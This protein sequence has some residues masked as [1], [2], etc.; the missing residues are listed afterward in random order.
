ML[1]VD[2][3][4]IKAL[5]HTAPGACKEDAE[6][7]YGKLQN[8][9]IFSGFCEADWEAIWQRILSTSKDCLI[10]S[11]TSLFQDVNYL[12]GPAQCVKRLVGLSTKYNTISSALRN[13]F[14]KENL[15]AKQ[16]LIQESE[17]TFTYRPGSAAEHID[18]ACRQ[19]WIAAMRD[20][21]EIPAD[22]KKEG[23]LINPPRKANPGVL[24]K[25]VSLAY[26]LGFRSKQIDKLIQM[27]PNKKNEHNDHNSQKSPPKRCGKPYSRDRER[28]KLMLFL[29]KLGGDSDQ[30]FDA[31]TSSFIRKSVY[32]AF[33]DKPRVQEAPT[34]EPFH[35]SASQESHEPE[36]PIYN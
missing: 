25:F 12:E 34:S 33:F 26:Q 2:R 15:T 17:T 24:D 29:T 3:A 35:I 21:F 13:C 31:I 32:F 8:G 14:L 36:Q 28:E 22:S 7:L 6:I 16:F 1:K 19:V 11:F 18:A 9:K 5:Q 30:T 23:Q 4:T 10:P 27:N 20:W